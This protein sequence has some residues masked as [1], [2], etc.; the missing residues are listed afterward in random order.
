[1]SFSSDTIADVRA[2]VRTILQDEAGLNFPE[3]E[4][5]AGVRMAL[6]QLAAAV[7]RSR[8]AVLTLMHDGMSILLSD[9]SAVLVG[10]DPQPLIDGVYWPWDENLSLDRQHSQLAGFYLEEDEGASR[11]V[12]VAQQGRPLTGDMVRLR[13][14]LARTI[15]GLDGAP[16]TTLFDDEMLQG[17]HAACGYAA[18]HGSLDRVEGDPGRLER[19]SQG[20]LDVWKVWLRAQRLRSA[21]RSQ[22]PVQHGWEAP[23]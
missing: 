17:V 23:I 22:L 12:L 2:A 20:K 10:I 11:L 21:V 18:Q 5:D 13:Y 4:I 14:T 1:M 16:I 3:A 9:Y 6:V 19:F 8:V 7:P 15:A